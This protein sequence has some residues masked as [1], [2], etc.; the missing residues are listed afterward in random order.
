[1]SFENIRFN[2]SI[3]NFTIEY[4]AIDNTKGILRTGLA[5]GMDNFDFS[6]SSGALSL[7]GVS[8]GEL[9]GQLALSATAQVFAGGRETAQGLT[10][11]SQVTINQD[12]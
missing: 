12:T 4:D 8:L 2:A 3:D 6:F 7:G 11:H 9:S 5:L 1:M 10:L